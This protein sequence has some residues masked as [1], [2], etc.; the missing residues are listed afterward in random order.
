MNAGTIIGSHVSHFVWVSK[1]IRA[2]MCEG[3]RKTALVQGNEEETIGW[4]KCVESEF[5]KLGML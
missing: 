3:A 4:R 2:E 5:G 1:Q